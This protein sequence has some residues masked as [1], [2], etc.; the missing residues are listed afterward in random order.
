M[1]T[2][3]LSYSGFENLVYLAIRLLCVRHVLVI[4]GVSITERQRL[5]TAFSTI[6]HIL[7]PTISRLTYNGVSLKV[8]YCLEPSWC[9]KY[10]YHFDSLQCSQV[11]DLHLIPRC[12]IFHRDSIH[13]Q[14]IFRNVSAHL[15]WNSCDYKYDFHRFGETLVV[16]VHQSP[17]TK[18]CF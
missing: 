12:P 16:R 10:I 2:Y 11:S 4:A 6:C 13:V 15:R 1:N 17:S 5:K 8:S 14:S 18:F 3:L 7:N 9:E